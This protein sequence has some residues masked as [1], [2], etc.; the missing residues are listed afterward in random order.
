VG[1]AGST[2]ALARSRRARSNTVREGRC[3]ELGAEMEVR[4]EERVSAV[5]DREPFSTGSRRVAVIAGSYLICRPAGWQVSPDRSSLDEPV[6][7][8]S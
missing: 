4:P 2:G 3:D 5:E 1:A 8:C 6:V 7:S